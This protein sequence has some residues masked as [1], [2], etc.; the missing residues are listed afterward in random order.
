M[1]NYGEIIVIEKFLNS[2]NKEVSAHPFVVID[3]N[4]GVIQGIEYD[5]SAA[6]LTSIKN[7]L[8]KQK[9]SKYK[10][11]MFIS[12]K[13]GVRKDSFLKLNEIYYFNEQDINYYKV[14]KIDDDL[15]DQIDELIFELDQEGEI[16]DVINNLPFENNQVIDNDPPSKTR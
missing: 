12:A 7:D 14:G 8:H 10:V 9:Y 11:N 1:I 5:I 4:A 2:H 15:M 13:D 3:N 16:I 6:M